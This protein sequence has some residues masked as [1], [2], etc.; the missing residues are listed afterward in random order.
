MPSWSA[1]I[2][3]WMFQSPNSKGDLRQ[4]ICLAEVHMSVAGL[5]WVS[6]RPNWWSIGV[7]AP[8]RGLARPNGGGRAPVGGS[9]RAPVDDWLKWACPMG[10]GHAPAWLWQN[11]IFWGKTYW[12]SIQ[13][14][15]G[16]V[17]C[18]FHKGCGGVDCWLQ[19]VHQMGGRGGGGQWGWVI[20]FVFLRA[21]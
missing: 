12:F 7:G 18:L 21:E 20:S 19:R 9:E 6:G 17:Q 3:H 15:V 10:G 14:P 13:C 5:G 2:L 11:S 4:E 8:H 1:H 16:V